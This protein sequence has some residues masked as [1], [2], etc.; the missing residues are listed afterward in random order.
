MSTAI[1]D[2][3]WTYHDDRPAGRRPRKLC[4]AAVATGRYDVR[5]DAGGFCSCTAWFWKPTGILVYLGTYKNSE[6]AR[7]ACQRQEGRAEK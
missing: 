6:S 7:E 4:S 2:L 3:T 1:A 5:G